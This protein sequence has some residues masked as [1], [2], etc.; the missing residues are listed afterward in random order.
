MFMYMCMS[1]MDLCP[2]RADCGLN[3]KVLGNIERQYLLLKPY[4]VRMRQE[5]KVGHGKTDDG[6][7]GNGG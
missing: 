4:N 2:T 1:I 5:T 7:Q 3:L 6:I